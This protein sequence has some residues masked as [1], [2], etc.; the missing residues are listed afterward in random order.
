MARAQARYA[1]WLGIQSPQANFSFVCRFGLEIFLG[2]AMSVGLLGLVRMGI[3]NHRKLASLRPYMIVANFILG[4]V[5]TTPEVLTQVMMFVPLQL[6]CE[7][8]IWV[9]RI[10]GRRAEKYA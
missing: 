2:L 3:L 9:A 5:L 1:A 4:A 8:S 10:W 6:L 7:V